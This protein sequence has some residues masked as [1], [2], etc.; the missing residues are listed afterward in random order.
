MHT[1]YPM[2]QDLTA[3][4]A[5]SRA[6]VAVLIQ[7]AIKIFTDTEELVVGLVKSIEVAQAV[8]TVVDLLEQLI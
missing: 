2:V 7:A 4:L 8:I 1:D 6:E 5:V 3:Q